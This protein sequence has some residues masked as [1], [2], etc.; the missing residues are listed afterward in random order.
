VVGHIIGGVQ[1]DKQLKAIEDEFQ[2]TKAPDTSWEDEA[3]FRVPREPVDVP[4]RPV[5]RYPADDI[6]AI[7]PDNPLA[8]SLRDE[9]KQMIRERDLAARQ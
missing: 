8:P 2:R 6:D 4:K 3:A 7:D 5:Y 1:T 9:Y